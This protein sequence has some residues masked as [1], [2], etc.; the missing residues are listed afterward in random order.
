[1]E[2]QTA[3]C[4][5][6]A[7]V[8]TE[9]AT[10]VGD[11]ITDTVSMMDLISDS[12]RGIGDVVSVIASV[13]FQSNIQSLNACPI[14]ARARTQSCGFSAMAR[15]MHSLL[16]HSAAASE[17]KGLFDD[18]IEKVGSGSRLV[19]DAA[20]SMTEVVSQVKRVN[21]LMAEITAASQE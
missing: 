17:I 4:L 14:A 12:R 6:L 13:A 19:T 9:R 7:N 18:S 10:E 3:V 15:K 1:M 5:E 8:V 16:G 2:H 11:A 20:Q 21:D